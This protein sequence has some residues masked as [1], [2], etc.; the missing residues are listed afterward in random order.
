MQATHRFF[1]GMHRVLIQ[2]LRHKLIG[3]AI[4]AMG[5]GG[6]VGILLT[7]GMH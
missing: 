6:V 2:R 5:A 3:G 4:V 7:F 1:A